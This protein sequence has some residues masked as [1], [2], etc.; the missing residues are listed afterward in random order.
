[1][2]RTWLRY[3][4][5]GDEVKQLQEMLG[6]KA[7]GIFGNQTRTAVRNFQREHDLEVDGIVGDETWNALLLAAD[8]DAVPPEQV[9]IAQPSKWVQPVDYKQY[10]SR[11]RN[12]HYP[13]KANP[14]N[15][16]VKSG[17]GVCACADILATFVDSRITPKSVA[18]YF[19]NK[20]FH[21]DSG[22]AWA[23]FPWAADRYGL[24]CK[25]D[26]KIAVAKKYLAAGGYV[27]CS[28]KAGYWTKGGHYIC[29]WKF[30]DRYMYAN[31][32]ASA[33]R[34]RQKL[35]DFEAE[36]KQYFCFLKKG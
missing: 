31:D 24:I 14:K 6:I 15:T 3:G 32:P 23:A 30:D 25:Q 34:K 2:S 21:A 18:T 11:W 27:V 17:C 26:S 16:I 4:S 22:T 12:Y 33:E 8:A 36:C 10:D 29:A 28:M 5:R 1:M 35:K 7:D 13:S 20:G 19:A 9:E